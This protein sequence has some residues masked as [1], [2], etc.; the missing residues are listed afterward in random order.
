[1]PE[2][3]LVVDDDVDSLKLIGLML[4]RHGYEVSAA[5]AGNQALVKANTEQPDLIILDVMMPDMNGYEVCRR[6]RANEQTSSIPIIMFTAKTLIDD[7]VAGFEAGADDYLTKPTH[8]AELA[9]R[10]KSIL[11]RSNAKRRQGSERG[12]VIGVLGVKG[13][14]GATTIA[15]N[16]A[17]AYKGTNNSPVVADF[18]LGN[19]SLGLTLGLG[20]SAGMSNLLNRPAE[21]INADIINREMVSHQTGL[22]ALLC[23]ARPRESLMSFPV[24]TAN[25]IIREMRSIGK[26]SIFDLGAGFSPVVAKLHSSMDKLLVVVDPA[27]V[28][29]SM[30]RELLAELARNGKEKIHLIVVNRNQISQQPPWHEVEHVLDHEIQAIISSAPDLAYQAMEAGMPIVNYQPNA[31]ISNQL[32]K[33]AE[34]LKVSGDGA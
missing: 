21:E 30:A 3:I 8:P 33:L 26:P 29:L 27:G 24:E 12:K 28:T 31:I 10:V 15:L 4:Q 20:R 23:S 18:R 34:D 1:M 9:S 7:K 16:L 32:A 17:A 5:S 19:G 25:A 14:V 13:G 2:K 22:R 6:L 11:Q